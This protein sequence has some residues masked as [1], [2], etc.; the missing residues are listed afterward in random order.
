M[1]AHVHRH[2]Y[3]GMQIVYAH[4]PRIK[5]TASI[6]T[7]PLSLY[8]RGQEQVRLGRAGSKSGQALGQVSSKSGRASGFIIELIQFSGW[9][10]ASLWLG[11]D[12]PQPGPE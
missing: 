3:K 1:T 11:P 10:R 2:A 4:A 8:H 9:A 6:N 7:S 12:Q 5:V